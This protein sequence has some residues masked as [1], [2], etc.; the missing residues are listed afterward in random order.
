[1]TA[2]FDLQR[3]VRSL[4]PRRLPLPTGVFL[5]AWSVTAILKPAFF[6]QFPEKK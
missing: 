4:K 2:M 1:M 6:K 5:T 3:A